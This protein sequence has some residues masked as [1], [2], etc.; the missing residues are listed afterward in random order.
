MR[1]L[2]DE[3]LEHEVYHRL[4]NYGHDIL[5][6]EVSDELSKGDTDEELAEI[7]RTEDWIIVT[8]DDDFRDSF[9]EDDYSAVLFFADQS[10]SAKKAADVLH[11]ISTYYE[12]EQLDGFI[13][14]GKSWL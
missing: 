1:F 8:Y 2:L 7:S 12:Q 9:S 3:N 14:V 13:T 4:Q 11:N 10:L 5:H 6:V